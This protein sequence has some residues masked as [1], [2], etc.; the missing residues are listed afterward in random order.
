MSEPRVPKKMISPDDWKSF[1][2][3]F[4]A[5]NKDRRARF[6]IFRG[7][8]AQEEGQEAHLLDVKLV[9]D[10]DAKNVE[11]RRVDRTENDAGEI[12]DVITNVRGIAVQYDTDKSEDVLEITDDQNSLISLRMESKVDGAS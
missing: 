9:S 7:G 5:R 2:Q 3:E 6:N 12:S 11:V 8:T 10:G 4:S 1:L